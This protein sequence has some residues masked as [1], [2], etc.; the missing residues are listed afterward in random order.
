[1]H[2][3]LFLSVSQEISDV[4]KNKEWQKSRLGK[5]D[6][7]PSCLVNLLNT[8][9]NCPVPCFAFYGSDSLCF[10]NEKYLKVCEFYFKAEDLGQPASELFGNHWSEIC[11][12]V[13]KVKETGEC[14][15]G[16]VERLP[17]LIH[18]EVSYNPYRYL[19]VFSD[20]G[21]V[22][23]VLVNYHE[24]EDAQKIF[25]KIEDTREE[26][27]FAIGAAE[28]GTWDYDPKN[29]YLIV[30]ERISEWFGLRSQ[31]LPL[32]HA[33]A[34]IVDKDRERVMKA[35]EKSLVFESG[36]EYS[37]EYTIKNPLNGIERRI[38]GKG[39]A[40]FNEKKE[41]YRFRGTIQD[42]TQF[43]KAI[44]KTENTEERLRM[45]LSATGMGMFEL[46]LRDDQI[47]YNERLPD[48][49]GLS[50][51]QKLR[52]TDFKDLLLEEDK[53]IVMTSLQNSFITGTYAYEARIKRTDGRVVWLKT[54]GR[55]YHDE[56][57]KPDRILG[58]VEDVTEE[59]ER[60]QKLRKSEQKLRS[61]IENSPF[62]IA[63]YEGLEM[64]VTMVNKAVIDL[65]GKGAD[66]VGKTF[67]E[68]LP[69]LKDF[70]F[71][72]HLQRV[73]KT[74]IPF[75]E[76]NKRVDFNID[77]RMQKH[78]FDYNY[79]PLF[80]EEGKV[81][82]V[83][84]TAADVTN[85]V[86]A[87]IELEE[88]EARFRLLADSLPQLIWAGD[89]YGNLN[90]WNRAT[91]QY[92]GVT[93]EQ[94]HSGKWAEIVHPEDRKEN[95]RRWMESI[96]TGKG[97]LLEHRFKTADGSYRWQLSRALP[98]R[99]ENNEIVR[100]VGSST[101]ID[102][103]K[104]QEQQKDFFISMASHELKTPLTS[105]KAYIQ[106]LMSKFEKENDEFVSKSLKA[107]NKQ[108]TKLT[109]LIAELLD[110]SKIK[111]G[112]LTL[113]YQ[114]FDLNELIDDSITETLQINPDHRIVFYQEVKPL[115]IL[116]DRDRLGQVMLNMLS[117][118]IKYSPGKGD[119]TVRSKIVN[120]EIMVVVEDQGIGINHTDKT[121][122][123]DR[124]FRV[125]GANEETFPGF[126]IGLYL[127]KDII[128]RHKGRVGVESELGKG[129]VFYFTLPLRPDTS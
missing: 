45:A 15:K 98:L 114:R 19:P 25:D 93:P 109:G 39:K 17:S 107:V 32:A 60:E 102:E 115:E 126:G 4:L 57:G 27:G 80:N 62:P 124:F 96:K 9:F 82:G 128:S 105:I 85:V 55:V 52:H 63:I 69:E 88:S 64:T 104:E 127:V 97:F 37:A 26:L 33:I 121:K 91:Y 95:L 72:D 48:I 22:E 28:L 75:S 50:G 21:I 11:P 92:C 66:I 65:W 89:K 7:W 36:G 119:I 30:N 35:I 78:Y 108:I 94:L 8:M 10:F 106:I 31:H 5:I 86:T 84:N 67:L 116:G 74:G 51:T 120:E 43:I 2:R 1:M 87:K 79:T 13:E 34:C 49:F 112:S 100:W 24:I 40:Y 129:S 59:K 125:G 90:Y 70:E 46:F 23:A 71:V 58:T 29:D 110:L 101:D 113:E 61:L 6:E 3:Q 14:L 118:A 18:Y 99:D 117:N 122:V 16:D 44:E 111:A 41:A 53:E 20:S 38:V 81:F 123:F 54:R 68:V 42:I 56:A 103:M 12:Y 73:Y 83:M 47:F 77:G 76:L